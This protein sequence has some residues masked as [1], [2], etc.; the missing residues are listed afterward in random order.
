MSAPDAKRQR[1]ETQYE[2]LYHPVI[3]GRAEFVR[4]AFEASGVAYTDIANENPPTKDSMNGYGEVKAVCDPEST[5][6]EDG[7]PPVFAP[8]A[9]RVKGGRDDGKDLVIHQTSNILMYVGPKLDLIG[10]KTE[11]LYHCNQL[12]LTAL[13]LNNECH[14]THHPVAVMKY[15]EEQKE[16][17]LKKATDF[18]ENR[19]PKF[20][21]FFERALKSNEAAGK[22]K[23]LVGKAITFA[24]TTLWQVLDG[25]HFAFPKELEFRTKDYPLLSETFY[26]GIKDEEWLQKYL[27][28][29]KR[30]PYSMGIFRHYPELDRQ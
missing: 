30:K 10:T 26:Q 7:N 16:E 24:D 29:G 11:D 14:D 9:L 13:D 19:I 15:Y 17:S 5:G 2:L 23:Y 4:L 25:L 1:I 8:P 18:R 28:S 21:S 20:F 12:T 3:P 27:S 22:G 6:D